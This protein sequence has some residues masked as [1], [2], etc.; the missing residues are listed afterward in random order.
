MASK[1]GGEEDDLALVAK[2]QR[3]DGGVVVPVG[4][5]S[6]QAN[7][8]LAVTTEVSD[9]RFFSPNIIQSSLSHPF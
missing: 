4:N 2:R 8:Q 9:L 7:N 1:R 6:S 5:T 3:T